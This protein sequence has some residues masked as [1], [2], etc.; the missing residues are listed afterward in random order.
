MVVSFTQILERR[1][2]AKLDDSARQFIGYAVEGAN[3]MEALLA[4]LRDYWHAAESREPSTKVDLNA[5]L[6]EALGNLS[7][8]RD[9]A[10]AEITFDSLPQAIAE[11]ML[12]VQLF[13][14]LVGNAL[15]YR[16]PQRP[17]KVHVGVSRNEA[18]CRFYVTDNGI[19]IQPEYQ[20][21]VFGIFRRLHTRQ[22]Y[23]GTGIGLALCQT[24]VQRHGG[25][26][27]VESEYGEGSTFF[28]TLPCVESCLPQSHGPGAEPQRNPDHRTAPD[29]GGY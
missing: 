10:G 4:G 24:I 26:I 20:E 13:Q 11:H 19:G 21:Q 5:C 23:A 14:N 16:H 6:V 1:Y 25:R 8:S 17:L 28:F 3:R 2:A 18:V 29:L 7:T 15:K 12:M 27:W 9:E 22:H